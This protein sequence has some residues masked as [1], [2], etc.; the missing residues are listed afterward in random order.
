MPN[1]EKD[2]P[3]DYP[4][5]VNLECTLIKSDID[6]ELFFAAVARSFHVLFLAPI[7]LLKG[8]AN[9]KQQVAMRASLIPELLPYHQQLLHYLQE[10]KKSGRKLILVT[11]A[12][13]TYA[14]KIADY[15]DLFDEVLASDEHSILCD[16]KRVEL[17]Q[18][19]HGVREFDYA[20][21]AQTD[22]KIWR[23]ARKVILVNPHPAVR[24]A[25]SQKFDIEQ[26]FDDRLPASRVLL[27]AIR[28][29]QWLKNIL[30]F[31]PL[32][33]A[34]RID[35]PQLVTQA[36]LSF[37]VFS[38]CTTSVYLLN[39]LF[40]LQS[41][42]A[43]QRKRDR[44]LA[45]GQLSI[46][47]ATI[48]I[49]VS[50]LTAI[51]IAYFLP[52]SFLLVLASYYIL[53][54]LYSLWAKRVVLLDVL[55]LAILYTIRIV[56]GGAAVEIPPSFWLL[57][58]SMFL[59]LSLAIIKRYTEL[60]T[61]NNTNKNSTAGRDYNV[62]DIDLLVSIGTS[63]GLIAV[64][65]LALY[66]NSNTVIKM[67]SH[68]EVIWF[69]C[70]VILYWIGRAWLLTKRGEMHDDP[71]IFAIKDPASWWVFAITI[72]ILFFAK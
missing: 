29:H 24:T 64:L 35:N 46:K 43:H 1:Q 56:A 39:D 18:S 10:Q 15:L 69:L 25:A 41:D 31:V 36:F 49:L 5:C 40:D 48:V 11:E 53:T 66:I 42:R 54:L 9:F 67:Y 62:M 45:A 51:T 16:D 12:N 19:K 3:P 33:A 13:N 6:Y 52:S 17:I 44:P 47:L 50:L 65:V 37:I 22:K 2:K 21:S 60:T 23:Y 58:F 20:G 28:P 34:H 14:Q 72:G 71:V 63:S 70:P 38:L 4:L 8:K 26:I 59:F 30:L 27:S 61:L 32:L 55:I 57:A 68:P 7:W